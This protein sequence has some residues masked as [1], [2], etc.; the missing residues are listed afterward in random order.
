MGLTCSIEAVLGYFTSSDD[1]AATLLSSIAWQLPVLIPVGLGMAWVA[2][3]VESIHWRCTV[4]ASALVQLPLTAYIAHVFAKEF[5]VIPLGC[6]LI[7]SA[8]LPRL[9]RARHAAHSVPVLA[10]PRDLS[11]PRLRPAVTL[12]D[13]YPVAASEASTGTIATEPNSSEVSTHTV[14]VIVEAVSDTNLTVTER[15][16]STVPPVTI[17]TIASRIQASVLVCEIL[18]HAQLA[19][20]LPPTDFTD[21]INRLLSICTETSA[22]REGQADRADSECFRA[23]FTCAKGSESHA[24]SAVLCALALKHRIEALSEECEIKWGRELDVRIGVNTGE[25]LA[26]QFGPTHSLRLGIAGESAEWGRRLAG[27]NQ[28]YGSR[29]LISAQTREMAEPAV[30]LRPIDLLQRQLPPEA[31]EEVFELLAIAGTLTPEAQS[32]LSHYKEGFSHFR[33]RNWTAARRFLKAAQ[34]THGNDDAI[35]LLL[36]RIDEQEALAGLVLDGH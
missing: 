34:P 12:A 16:E 2:T 6:T 27:A 5:P 25:V 13:L 7:G 31:P 15:E 24:E 20:S 1:S 17:E 28:L 33:K 32:R 21:L 19:S 4:L 30:E 9:L 14:P 29:I 18:N 8:L 10:P 35:D 36:H 26:A 11:K 3:T 23:F 22:A